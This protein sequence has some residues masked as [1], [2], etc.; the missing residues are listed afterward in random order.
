[1]SKGQILGERFWARNNGEFK[2]TGFELSGSN[3]VCS[4]WRQEC[5]ASFLLPELVEFAFSAIRLSIFLE[6]YPAFPSAL[7]ITTSSF[8]THNLFF[9]L[10]LSSPLYFPPFTPLYKCFR[11][12]LTFLFLIPFLFT[13]TISHFPSYL[14]LCFKMSLHANPSLW[15]WVW[16]G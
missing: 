9:F 10:H 13:T 16:F 8:S 12:Q 7:L 5:M 3:C 4:V 14:C 11:C 1:M 2:I 15:K 6:L